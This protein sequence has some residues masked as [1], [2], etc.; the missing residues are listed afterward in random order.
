M[1]AHDAHE[2]GRGGFISVAETRNQKYYRSEEKSDI[3]GKRVKIIL[4]INTTRRSID[5]HPCSNTTLTTV[6]ARNSIDL[7][8][9]R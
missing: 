8:S 3:G 7:S 5:N 2:G 9:F 1:L 6:R 4:L